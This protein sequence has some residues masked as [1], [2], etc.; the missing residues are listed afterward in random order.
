MKLRHLAAT[1]VLAALAAP[2][3]AADAPAKASPQGDIECAAWASV[4]GSYVEDDAGDSFAMAFNY[5]LGRYQAVAGEDFGDLLTAALRAIDTDVSA[6]ER[7]TD[8]CLPR[9]QAHG[10]ALQA[11]ADRVSAEAGKE[12]TPAADTPES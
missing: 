3:A 10:E 6:Y 9:W 8:A 5:F 12:E 4:T 2:A 1:A 11:W 7:Y